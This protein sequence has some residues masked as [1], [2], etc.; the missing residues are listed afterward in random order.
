[1]GVW[2]EKAAI[3]FSGLGAAAYIIAQLM[4]QMRGKKTAVNCSTTN[5]EACTTDCS[6]NPVS[7]NKEIIN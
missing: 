5:A 4:K 6:C 3:V 2:L 1:M 7:N